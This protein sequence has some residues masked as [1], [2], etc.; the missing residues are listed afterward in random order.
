MSLSEN[1]RSSSGDMRSR[2]GLVLRY[3]RAADVRHDRLSEFPR[4]I[5]ART[6][7][8][9][10]AGDAID[11]RIEIQEGP[12][13]VSAHGEVAWTT[14]LAKGTVAGVSLSGES[15]RDDV[16]LDLLLGL[17]T[18]GAN[19]DT[20]RRVPDRE[21]LRVMLLQP[22]SMLK[23]V[24]ESALERFAREKSRGT[25][26]VETTTDATSFIAA[27]AA[28]NPDLAIIDC[29]GIAG[30]AE[31]LLGAVRSGRSGRVPVIILSDERSPRLQD[32]W[33]VTIRKP[34]WMRGLIDT[35]DLLLR[36]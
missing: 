14:P 33:T 30:A 26:R 5:M 18:L 3:A 27:V 6:D 10:S 24:I 12:A 32:R 11:V 34:V 1:A 22:N 35:V 13:S 17:R 16:K 23:N 7:V 9:V 8:A 19:P 31:P 21:E 2:V 36:A 4:G 20:P 15:R 28:R 25:I 29:D